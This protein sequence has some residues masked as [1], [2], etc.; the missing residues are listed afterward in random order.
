M[1]FYDGWLLLVLLAVVL[2]FGFLGRGSSDSMGQYESKSKKPFQALYEVGKL[3]AYYN[4]ASDITAT[5]LMQRAQLT[6]DIT[7]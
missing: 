3:R 6:Y 1:L 2:Q 5:Y 7:L 4:A